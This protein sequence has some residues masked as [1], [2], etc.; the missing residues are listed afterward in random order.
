MKENPKSEEPAPLFRPG[1][2]ETRPRRVADT[3]LP[4]SGGERK[5]RLPAAR[6]QAARRGAGIGGVLPHIPLP[7]KYSFIARITR[8]LPGRAA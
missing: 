1:D 8:V 6:V 4:E 2:F 5:R 7:L 3:P